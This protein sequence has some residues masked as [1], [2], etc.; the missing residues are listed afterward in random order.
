MNRVQGMD[1]NE[2]R[3]RELYPQ[4]VAILQ[5]ENMNDAGAALLTALTCLAWHHRYCLTALTW[6]T[7]SSIEQGWFELSKWG[8]PPEAGLDHY[9]TKEEDSE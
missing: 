8:L 4:L 7:C 3:V 6:L 2:E 9:Q 5:D 1:A